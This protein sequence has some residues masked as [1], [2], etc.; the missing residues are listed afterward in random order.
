MTGDIEFPARS[1]GA[2]GPTQMGGTIGSP[3]PDQPLPAERPE[4][5]PGAAQRRTRLAGCESPLRS[6]AGVDAG[7]FLTETPVREPFAARPLAQ[8]EKSAAYARFS[9]F[10]AAFG[11]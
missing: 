6:I 10:A 8:I 7:Y 2:P 5:Y 9:A 11:V 4:C 3:H 1:A